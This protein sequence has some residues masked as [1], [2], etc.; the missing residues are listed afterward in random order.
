MN[1]PLDF[2]Y[3]VTVLDKIGASGSITSKYALSTASDIIKEFGSRARDLNIVIT[4]ANS[5]IGFESARVLA[6][7]GA[8]VVLACRSKK[9]GDEAILS[10]KNIKKENKDANVSFIQLDLGSKASILAFSK[11]FKE[12]KRPLNVLL[13]NAG[14]MACPLT[15]TS[16]GFESQFGVN[17]LGHFYLTYLLWDNLVQSCTM[18][19]PS[20]VINV[21]SNG[22]YLFPYHDK[23]RAIDF[24]DL[25]PAKN[26][27]IWRRYG[28]SKL[29]N[30]LFASELQR[31][32]TAKGL[33]VISMSLHP[34]VIK[35][36]LTRYQNN[37][38]Y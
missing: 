23:D 32:S 14:I 22:G 17:H 25:Q 3:F 28:E 31:R 12:S 5:G 33:P 10:I 2:F 13:N 18:E 29:A 27:N 34:G 4:G 38:Y 26:Y 1:I 37:N 35:T 9:Y 19:N 7:H 8:K 6:N 20:R 21:S 36:N 24:A 15:R 11:Q 16:D 30:A